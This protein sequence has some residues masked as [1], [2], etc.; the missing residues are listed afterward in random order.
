MRFASVGTHRIHRV[1]RMREPAELRDA[2]SVGW[3][4]YNDA[5]LSGLTACTTPVRETERQAE[6]TP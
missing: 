2:A 4:K 3:V 1:G 5:L 6:E